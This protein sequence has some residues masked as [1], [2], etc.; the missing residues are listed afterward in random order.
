MKKPENFAGNTN[1]ICWKIAKK[2]ESKENLIKSWK[3]K[4]VI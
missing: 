3:K 1:V 2:Y 4:F